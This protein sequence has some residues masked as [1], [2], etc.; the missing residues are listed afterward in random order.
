MKDKTKNIIVTLVFVTILII[1][2]LLNIIKKD[3][4]ISIAE[5]RRLEQFPQF[6]IS[7]LFNGT[8]FENFDK[9]V[10]DQFANRDSFRRLKVETELYAFKKKDYNNVYEYKGYIIKNEYPLNEKSVVNVA[11]K[12]KQIYDMYELKNNNVYFTMVPDKNYFVSNGNLKLDYNKMENI[13][14][15]NLPFAQYIKIDDMLELTDYYKTDTHWKQENILKVASKIANSMNVTIEKEYEQVKIADF[16]GVYSGQL[17]LKN[18]EN[19]EIKILINNTL[20]KCKVYNYETGE[21]S[22][23]YNLSKVNSLDKYDIYLSGAVPI[24]TIENPEYKEEKELVV[25]RDS[26]GSS[27]IPLLATGYS[28]ITVIDTRYISPKL[29]KEYVTFENKDVLFMYSTLIINDSNTLK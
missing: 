24:L 7:K 14:K 15:T 12:V 20:K 9:Y 17:A 13:L 3:E 8:F 5:R 6:S 28:K 26:F 22:N 18:I 2:M 27:I 25:F 21:Y 10:V 11:N 16:K 4:Q 1:T 23:I 29:L 19:D